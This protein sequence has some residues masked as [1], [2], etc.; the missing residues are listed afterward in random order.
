MIPKERITTMMTDTTADCTAPGCVL[1]PH[2]PT[3]MHIGTTRDGDGWTVAC[4]FVEPGPWNIDVLT[5]D[6]L[7]PAAARALAAALAATAAECE[8]AS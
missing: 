8:A 3:D 4:G 7:T 1:P 5:R 2:D 6:A